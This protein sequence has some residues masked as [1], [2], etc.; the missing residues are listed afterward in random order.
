[1]KRSPAIFFVALSLSLSSYTASAQIQRPVT[2]AV[3]LSYLDSTTLEFNKNNQLVELLKADFK[4]QNDRLKRDFILTFGNNLADSASYQLTL[5]LA[6]MQIGEERK[7]QS[8]RLASATV[9]RTTHDKELMEHKIGS[10]DSRAEINRIR[11]SVAISIYVSVELKENNLEK[12]SLNKSFFADYVWQNEFVVFSGHEGLLT[13]DEQK[14]AKSGEGFLPEKSILYKS[15]GAAVIKEIS[16]ALNET[17]QP[18][19]GF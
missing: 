17:L 16:P 6:N 7:E 8:T 5:S 11:K 9:S 3:H 18:Q 1:M 10:T 14:L 13:R 19:K 15:L 12:I 4:K 2:I